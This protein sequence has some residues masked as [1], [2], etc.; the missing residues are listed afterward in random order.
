MNIICKD[1]RKTLQGLSGPTYGVYPI[2]TVGGYEFND[3]ILDM[4]YG[5]GS[6][7]FFITIIEC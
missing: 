7:G 3:L 6:Q 2:C 1:F 5:E 4:S